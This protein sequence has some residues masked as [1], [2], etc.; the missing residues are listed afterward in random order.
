[1]RFFRHVDHLASATKKHLESFPAKD[2]QEGTEEDFHH[3]RDEL[4]TIR[5]AWQE[6]HQ[7]VKSATDAD[8]LNQPN[9]LIAAMLSRTRELPGLEHTDFAI[10][11]TDT[12]NYL[13]VNPSS[14][15]TTLKE[16]AFIVAAEEGFPAGLGLIGIPSTQGK[17]LFL[18]CLVAHE[19]AEYVYAENSLN[20]LLQP[21]AEVA[22]Q[23]V[24]GQEYES[25]DKT[26]KSSCIDTVLGWAKELFCD[27][28]A[29]QLI[30]PSYT[31]AYVE[32]FDLPNLLDRGGSVAISTARPPMRFYDKHPSHPFRVKHQADLL[33]RLDW[34]P[35]LQK[36]DSRYVRV[37]ES[38]VAL[39]DNQI[40]GKIDGENPMVEAFFKILPEISA[41][42]GK[43]TGKLDSGVHEFGQLRE[44]VTAYLKEGIV[45]STVNIEV[46]Q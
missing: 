9:A 26:Q 30:G 23:G 1:M 45:P 20:N 29:V 43:I 21:E 2:V 41:H 14:I 15:R 28:F 46:R 4:R 24:L 31:L 36:L 12:F 5:R 6:L 37:L 27:L 19:I 22:L 40:N 7:F 8:T 3:V 35:H 34:W 33:K 32:L 18:N 13:Q 25:R 17:S 38:R 44:H 11:H 39:D 16:L 42:L 10:F